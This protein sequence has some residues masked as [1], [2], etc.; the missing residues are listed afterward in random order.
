M[1]ERWLCAVSIRGSVGSAQLTLRKGPRTPFPDG[2]GAHLMRGWR[3]TKR[4]DRTGPE[5]NRPIQV[6]GMQE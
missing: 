3:A 6:S 1:R 2:F 5:A 4:F